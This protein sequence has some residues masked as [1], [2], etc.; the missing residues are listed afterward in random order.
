MGYSKQTLKYREKL[1]RSIRSDVAKMNKSAHA[2]GISG[3]EYLQVNIKKF[4]MLTKTKDMKMFHTGNL[5]RMSTQKLERLKEVSSGYMKN[6]KS[7]ASGRKKIF[8]KSL[9]TFQSRYHMQFDSKEKA[10]N[11]FNRLGAL[12]KSSVYKRL[13]ELGLDSEQIIELLN[14]SSAGPERLVNA[15]EEA[16]EIMKQQHIGIG[17]APGLIEDILEMMSESG[18]ALTAEQ[19]DSLVSKYATPQWIDN[20]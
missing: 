13:K 8:D 4:N 10:K 9:E 5:S 20:M 18:G 16:E 12:Q 15:M 7:T 19:Y 6:P 14:E 17:K 1:M 2:I 11:V 3:D